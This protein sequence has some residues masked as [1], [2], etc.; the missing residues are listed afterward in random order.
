MNLQGRGGLGLWT[1]PPLIIR[2]L[3]GVGL[4]PHLLALLT[5]CLSSCVRLPPFLFVFMRAPYRNFFVVVGDLLVLLMGLKGKHL[6]SE[7]HRQ[8]QESRTEQQ[9]CTEQ[10]LRA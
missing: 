5:E 2:R 8:W 3:S 4:L 10:R 1:P 6:K 9:S 7:K